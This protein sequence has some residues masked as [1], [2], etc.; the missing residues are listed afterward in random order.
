MFRPKQRA[1]GVLPLHVQNSLKKQER[2]LKYTLSDLIRERDFRIKCIS[3]DQQ[4]AGARLRTFQNRLMKSQVR[5]A[6]GSSTS[7]M[8]QLRNVC[9]AMPL[10][11]RTTDHYRLLL[12]SANAEKQKDLV[13]RAP[14]LKLQKAVLF[15]EPGNIYIGFRI[16]P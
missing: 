2:L 4:V 6:A 13:K 7:N 14:Q 8:Q 16:I 9:S 11:V 3:Q 1:R 15:H 5:S 12:N 10:A